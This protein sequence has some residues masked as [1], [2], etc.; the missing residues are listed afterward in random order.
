MAGLG[1]SGRC[2]VVG[3]FSLLGSVSVFAETNS[4]PPTASSPAV[5]SNS[6]QVIHLLRPAFQSDEPSPPSSPTA[7]RGSARAAGDDG[8]ESLYANL[9]NATG[10]ALIELVRRADPRCIHQLEWTEDRLLQIEISRQANVITVADEIP[11]LMQNYDGSHS[12]GILALFRYLIAAKDIHYWCLTLR[13]CG[14]AEWA[15]TDSYPVDPG[16]PVYGAVKKAVDAFVDHPQFTADGYEHIVTWSVVAQAIDSYDLEAL[17]LHLVTRQL[18]T[19]EPHYA[20]EWYFDEAMYRVLTIVYNGHRVSDFGQAFGEDQPLLHAFRDFAL[21]AGWVGTDSQWIA[22]QAIQEIGRY[23]KYMG[24]TNYDAAVPIIKAILDMYEDHPQGESMILRLIAEIDYN[25]A[26]NC[27]RYDLCDWYEGAGFNHNFRAAL[28]R[29]TRECPWMPCPEETIFI[30]AQA[31]EP[32][33]LDLACERLADHARV[34]HSMLGTD[35]M[36]IRGDNNRRLEI[37]IFNDGSSCDALESAAFGYFPDSCSG[38]YWEGDPTDPE[39]SAQVVMTEYTEDEHPLDPELAIWNFE[40]EYAHYLDGRYNLYGPYRGEDPSIHWWVEGFAEYFA[41]AVSPYIELPQL[42]STH[43]LTETL[44]HSGSIPTSYE[45]RHLVVHYLMEY[46]RCFVDELLALV[47]EGSYVE[48][49]S[50]MEQEAPNFEAGWQSWLMGD[51]TAT[52]STT[53]RTDAC[54]MSAEVTTDTDDRLVDGTAAVSETTL[55]NDEPT[56]AVQDDLD[57]QEPLPDPP[58][59][60]NT[61]TVSETT[62][63]N[64]EPTEAVQDDLDSQEPLPDPPTDVTRDIADVSEPVPD[65]S[66]AVQDDTAAASPSIGSAAEDQATSGMV[67]WGL[68]WALAGAAMGM[69][70]AVLF[71]RWRKRASSAADNR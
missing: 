43:S 6:A 64:D 23:T 69:A 5:A 35:C 32:E 34:F 28:F 7:P 40:H 49:R 24:T 15:T 53:Q 21:N 19:W 39:T 31:L 12:S 2:T 9:R 62:L 27:G 8:C 4:A 20:Q 61:V 66:E 46:Q 10:D 33:E 13:D 16:T 14:G 30:H 18:N 65:T 71:L 47:R 22:E 36:P 38:I 17:Y 44:L 59:Q 54:E 57:S 70:A 58:T 51:V 60:A 68:I 41:A 63:R 42:V 67:R 56:E 45:Q 37:F 29:Y 50:R 11:Q 25:D 52:D 1:L 55:R 26:T 48:Y 3:I